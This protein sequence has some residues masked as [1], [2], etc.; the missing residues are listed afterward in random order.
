M[1]DA[2]RKNT[3]VILWI[4][5][6]AFLFLMVLVWGAEQQV[7]CGVSQGV[8]GRVN[9]E[10][11]QLEYFNRVYQA[12]RDS[13]RQGRGTD[14]GPGDEAL[15]MEQSWNNVVEQVLLIQEARKRGLAPTDEELKQI[16]LQQPPPIF[17]T[18]PNFQTNGQFDRQKYLSLIQT[19]VDFARQ[20]EAYL[21]DTL[22][23]EKLQS[24][25]Y[26]GA[27]VSDDDVRQAFLD[28]NE[29]VRMTYRLFELRQYNLPAAVTDQE[30]EAWFKAHPEEF[31]LPPQATVRVAKLDR[32]PTESDVS[33]LRQ[34]LQDFAAIA[35]RAANGDSTAQNF[36]SL[37][38]TYSELPSAQNGGLTDHFVGPGELTPELETQ[39]MSLPEGGVSEPIQD[40]QGMH[41][42]Q[43]DSVKIEDGVR[44]V[45]F[46]QLMLPVG[47]SDATVSGLEEKMTQL[48]E[49][50]T[51]GK[52]AELA[53]AAGLT[54][55]TPPPFAEAGFIRGLESVSGPASWAFKAPVGTVGPVFTTNDAWYL[56]VLDRRSEKGK[57][58]FADLAEIAR[59]KTTEARQREMARK[60]AESFLALARNST[61]WRRA[62]GSDS[63]LVR[64]VGPFS[65]SAGIPGLGR[66]PEAMAAVFTTK[67]G[68]IA[69]PVDATRGVMVVKIEEKKGADETLLAAQKGQ[70]QTQLVSQ[71]RNEVY[72]DWLKDL[73]ESAEIK[74]YRELYFRS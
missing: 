14:P 73:K 64:T 15:L 74:D 28:R 1:L 6:V 31:Q 55:S 7:G 66:D 25:V 32:K 34:Q 53:Q 24:M 44:K 36:A 39:V 68:G 8:V 62:A 38:E 22:P 18:N 13:F 69:G 2:M 72:Q 5:V 70:I 49:T 16:A 60:E 48:R 9:G 30:A 29:T 63:T 65:K 12:N 37:A 35:Q 47:P 3:K 26:Q 19:N 10:P 43:I 40:R 20:L 11:I 41:L 54:V 52:F 56:I 33:D 51:P 42:V 50:L 21:R 27:Q 71:R 17:T 59:Q 58:T 67:A 57:A 45:R 4:T 46:R 23:V 61:D